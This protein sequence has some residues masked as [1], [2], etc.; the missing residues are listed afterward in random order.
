MRIVIIG[1]P[2]S[3][4]S[5]LAGRYKNHYC[6]DPKSLVKDVLP[7]TTYLPEGLEWGKD[8]DYVCE[9]W[10]TMPGP[11]TIEGVGAVRALAKWKGEAPC[12]S[13]VV[14]KDVHPY[15]VRTS[16][17]AMAKAVMTMWGRIADK[18]QGITVYR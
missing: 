3:G 12:D 18:Y 6:T 17:E 1:G 2:R 7:T 16:G 15:S 13:I 5:T 11:W 8:S 10:L 4:K 9:N 14:I